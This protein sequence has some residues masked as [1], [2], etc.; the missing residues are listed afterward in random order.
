VPTL[1]GGKGDDVCVVDDA[2][3]TVVEFA[4]EGAGGYERRS[5]ALPANV[6]RNSAYRVAT[7]RYGSSG[8][9]IVGNA[10]DN[11]LDGD[12]GADIIAGG[13]GNDDYV[14]ADGGDTILELSNEG[15][16]TL[17]ATFTSTLAANLENLILTTSAAVD[18]TGNALD[19][20][21]TGGSGMNVLTGLAG[22]DTLDGGGGA[23]RLVGGAGNDTYVVDHASDVVVELA[24]EGI[25]LVRTVMSFVSR[26]TSRISYCSNSAPSMPPATPPRIC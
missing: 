12:T 16:D 15:N 22:N 10:G 11:R 3:D 26:A 9:T 18:G 2:A 21:L 5:H 19:N 8:T 25:D 1:A 13:A 4:G 20:V 24:S 6:E 7:R 17:Y 14:L 23:D